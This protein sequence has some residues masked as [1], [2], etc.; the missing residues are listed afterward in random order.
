M[1]PERWAD[2]ER[3]YHEALER[4]AGDRAV[5]LTNA[6]GGDE[7]LRHEVQ[8]LLAHAGDASFLSRPAATS[9]WNTTANGQ[10]LIGGRMGPYEILSRIGGGGMGDVYRAR[11]TRLP[12]TVALKMPKA[13]LRSVSTRSQRH[14]PAQSSPRLHVA[15][16]RPR[17]PGDGVR[18]GI[19]AQRSA[20]SRLVTS[21]AGQILDALDAAHRL[22]IVHRD[23]K[24]AN[25]IVTKQGI[26]LLDFGL[27]HTESNDDDP[28]L[29]GTGAV[30]GTPAYMS[31]EQREGRQSDARTDIYA[32]GCVLYEMLT[33]KRVTAGRVPAAHPGLERVVKQ[34]LAEDPDDRFQNARDV[35]IALEW[36]VAPQTGAASAERGPYRRRLAINGRRH[37]AAE[38]AQRVVG[39]PSG[40]SRDGCFCTTCSHRPT[41]RRPLS[42]FEVVPDGQRFLVTAQ[43]QRPQPLTVIINWPAL[44]K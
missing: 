43:E 22:H 31:P 39:G 23:L 25:I 18:R 35:K 16:R 34:C 38:C 30:M 4:P 19:C 10:T 5:F 9:G 21:Y 33:G 20:A 1:T 29:T 41:R 7:A 17:L 36:A 24:P 6:C 32:F 11:D 3:L 26:K 14:R 28:S 2:V 40:P 27:A 44:M 12:R 13:L 37:G 8:S 15:R 42:R